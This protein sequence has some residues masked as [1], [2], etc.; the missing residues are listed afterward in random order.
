MAVWG[1]PCECVRNLFRYVTVS[2]KS[3]WWITAVLTLTLH[4]RNNFRF[5]RPHRHDVFADLPALLSFSDEDHGCPK[6]TG[7]PHKT[8]GITHG[9]AGPRQ[10]P[11]VVFGIKVRDS[12]KP[13]RGRLIAEH[14]YCLADM[15]GARVDIRP[16]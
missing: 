6:E 11:Q 13:M 8:A 7:V 2:V 12:T 10:D 3:A 5:P 9:T 1:Q 14:S 4:R 15:I 16:K